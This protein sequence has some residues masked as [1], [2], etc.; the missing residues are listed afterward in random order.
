MP[1]RFRFSGLAVAVFE[2]LQVFSSGDA[3]R[4]EAWEPF[5]PE[6]KT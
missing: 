5:L 2:L 1:D 6:K 3:E 4:V